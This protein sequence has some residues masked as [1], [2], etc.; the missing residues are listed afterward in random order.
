[1]NPSH[2]SWIIQRLDRARAGLGA[3]TV[4]SIADV[5]GIGVHFNPFVDLPQDSPAPSKPA[6]RMKYG[7]VEVS[8]LDRDL[9]GWQHLYFAG[10]MHKPMVCLRSSPPSQSMPFDIEASR[11]INQRSALAAALLQMPGTFDTGTLLNKICSV[12][13]NGDVRM[14][15]A[16]DPRKV[17]RIVTGARRELVDIYLPILSGKQAEGVALAPLVTGI[18]G[19]EKWQRDMSPDAQRALFELLPPGLL[20][21]I[22]REVGL[23]IP[24]NHVLMKETR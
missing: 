13:Y 14:G 4:Q 7:V 11:R 12:S 15:L 6:P 18:S 20:H 24:E 3:S 1:M 21:Q 19:S 5:L 17:A 10:R 9:R 8:E 22:S 2:Y 23:G 16:E